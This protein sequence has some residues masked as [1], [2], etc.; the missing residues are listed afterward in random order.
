LVSDQFTGLNGITVPSTLRDSLILL[1]VVLERQ[2]E[3]QPTEIMSDTG[4]NTDTIF[5]IFHLLGYR[6]SPRVG[7]GRPLCYEARISVGDDFLNW[8]AEQIHRALE[9]NSGVSANR[10]MRCALIIRRALRSKS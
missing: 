3:L 4:A 2:T 8:Q 9:Q 1:S 7:Q 10:P 6:F 5:G